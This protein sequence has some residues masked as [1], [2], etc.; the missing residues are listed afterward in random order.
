ML[1]LFTL[2]FRTFSSFGERGKFII[3]GGNDKA[4]KVWDWSRSVDDT[5]TCVGTDVAFSISVQKKVKLPSSGFFLLRIF[6][7]VIGGN[8][9][10]SWDLSSR[11]L[12]YLAVVSTTEPYP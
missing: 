5:L 11:F 6:T 2:N 4:V 9:Q 8:A 7:L 10:I 3:S 12:L 1:T